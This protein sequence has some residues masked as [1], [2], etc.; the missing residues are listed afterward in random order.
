L[1]EGCGA[2]VAAASDTAKSDETAIKTMR[3]RIQTKKEVGL[4]EDARE[5]AP[6]GRDR[7][8]VAIFVGLF[9]DSLS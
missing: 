6:W 3:T 7:G 4:Q 8:V 1:F 5:W 9:N 2:V